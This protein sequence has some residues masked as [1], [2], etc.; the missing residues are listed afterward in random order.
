[1]TERFHSQGGARVEQ[2][3]RRPILVV[4]DDAS[5]GAVIAEALADVGYQTV[6]FSHAESAL[7]YIETDGAALVLTDLTLS[8]MDGWEFIERMRQRPNGAPSIVV[9]TG[10]VV[11]AQSLLPP[12][13]AVLPKPFE[14]AE[15]F[16]MVAQW[17]TE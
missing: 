6:V 2:R 11:S 17:A 5:L 14:L 1:M 4:E 15:L 16:G 10:S 13:R 3:M 8:G 7:Q 12:I 9:M